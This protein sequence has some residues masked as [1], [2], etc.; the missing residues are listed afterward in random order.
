MSEN[1]ELEKV[2]AAAKGALRAVKRHTELERKEE[3]ARLK[4][5][6][7]ILKISNQNHAKNRFKTQAAQLWCSGGK[8]EKY[9]L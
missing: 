9:N 5:F 3:L 1:I 8:G 2:R 6:W 4:I 7:D